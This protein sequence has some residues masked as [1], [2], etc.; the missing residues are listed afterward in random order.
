MSNQRTPDTV[1]PFTLPERFL[2]GTATS[3]LQV[4]GGD[5]NNSWYAWANQGGVTDG[6]SP[7]HANDH[8]N[9]VEEDT[10]LLKDLGVQ[11]HRLGIEWA[12]IEPEPGTFSREAIDHYRHEIGLMREA[13]IV[14]LVTLHHFA[15]PIWL[16]ESGGWLVP[17]VIDRF[18]SYVD[19]V[20]T[21]LGDLVSDWI[22]INEPSVYLFE[23]FVAGE[24]PPG[25]QNPLDYFRGARF[26]IAAH[27]RAY[28]TIHRIQAAAGRSARVGVAHHIRVFEP[29]SRP[30]SRFVAR[31]Y[32]RFFHRRFLDP[33]SK[34]SDFLGINYY[35]RDIITATWKPGELFGSRGT[36]PGAPTSDLGWEIFP[37]GLYTVIRDL[38]ERHHLP[39]FITE[40]GICDKSDAKRVSFIYEHLYQ[41]RRLL[42]SGVP[43]ERYYHWTLM[44]NFEWSLGEGAPF[45]LYECNFRSQLRTL[46][47]SG[48]F[49]SELCR[50]R[51]V[52]PEMVETYLQS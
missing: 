46:R 14:P 36:P 2:L 15:N 24:S 35:T 42:D 6:S 34:H 1:K 33:M 26:M 51:G 37:E 32:D 19:R 45:G 50:L 41:V 18:D 29:G 30:G 4:E 16:E 8:W 48:R 9:R 5:R 40:N 47:T 12:R 10:N 38:H 7:I 20:V 21:D 28:R 52:T 11:T 27:E 43:V 31:L 39:V 3:G 25:R 17:T 13:G 44:D 23:G 22:T 49:Y